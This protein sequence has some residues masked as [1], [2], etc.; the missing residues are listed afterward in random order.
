METGNPYYDVGFWELVYERERKAYTNLLVRRAKYLKF[1]EAK[2]LFAMPEGEANRVQKQ[3]NLLTEELNIL[4]AFKL[5]TDDMVR[6][7]VANIDKIYEAY[8]DR[9]HELENELYK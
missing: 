2:D 4:Y 1:L 9:I 3:I 5:F 8:T 7:Y 6:C